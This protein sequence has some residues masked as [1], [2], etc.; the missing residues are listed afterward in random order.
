MKPIVLS[1]SLQE[2]GKRIRDLMVASGYTVKDIQIACSFMNP[3]AIYR[4]M[5]G[6]ALPS[7]ENLVILSRV[8]K[9]D[10]E[11]LLVIKEQEADACWMYDEC[12]EE[13]FD[14]AC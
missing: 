3:Q 14:I 12:T 1:I 5:R 10:V 11:S 2:T 6:E 13:D 8:L 4:W 7:V 9:T